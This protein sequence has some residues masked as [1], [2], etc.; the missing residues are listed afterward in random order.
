MDKEEQH[1]EPVKRK[2]ERSEKAKERGRRKHFKFCRM[3]SPKT[4]PHRYRDV[5]PRWWEPTSIG[6][7]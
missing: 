7:S 4:N 2:P 6:V 1:R 3:H 5:Y